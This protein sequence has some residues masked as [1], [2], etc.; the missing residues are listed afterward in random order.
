[1]SGIVSIALNYYGFLHL[2]YFSSQQFMRTTLGSAE[3]SGSK[4][5][6]AES[7]DKEPKVNKEIFESALDG[8]ESEDSP[9]LYTFLSKWYG[10]AD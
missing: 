10:G 1:M 5:V 3:D 4:P 6:V 8:F 7:R 2:S 9:V